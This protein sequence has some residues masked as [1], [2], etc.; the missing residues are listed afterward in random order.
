MNRPR[1]IPYTLDTL[2]RLLVRSG[3]MTQE[4]AAQALKQEWLNINAQCE[5][6]TEFEEGIYEQERSLIG[7]A[8]Q[9]MLLQRVLL[10]ADAM[11]AREA[12]ELATLGGAKALGRD[13]IGRIAPGM[14]ADLAVWDVSG[15]ESAGSWDP[16]ALLLAGPSRVRDLYVEGRKVVEEGRVVTIDTR[17]DA[18]E[19]RTAVARL[20]G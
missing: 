13:D 4:Q 7:E 16:A 5:A 2:T 11:S 20:A 1:H 15:V 14:R 19:A 12:L 18:D 3:D 9:A 8:R 17:K 6:T 10:G